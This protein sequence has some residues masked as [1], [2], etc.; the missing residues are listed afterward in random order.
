[1]T[2]D[3]TIFDVKLTPAH[4]EA[5]LRDIANAQL[6]VRYPPPNAATVLRDIRAAI[7]RKDHQ[8]R[9]SL[10][11]YAEQEFA[12]LNGWRIGTTSFHPDKIGKRTREIHFH[13]DRIFD[14]CKYFHDHGKAIA[15]VAQP[16]G[17]VCE[18]EAYS[19]AR[20]YCLDCHIPPYPKASI[21][22]PDECF[23]FVFTRPGVEV[24]WLREQVLGLEVRS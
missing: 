2:N 6:P 1:M 4:I 11:D 24:R 5:A 16:Y 21:Y 13:R 19:T 8:Q 14:H 18:N 20:H 23:F 17:H 3:V 22:Y 7:A 10:W 15:I 12:R 9:G